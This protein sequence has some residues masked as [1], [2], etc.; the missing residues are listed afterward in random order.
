MHPS[1]RILGTVWCMC[2]LSYR[3]CIDIVVCTPLITP[4]IYVNCW[5]RGIQQCSSSITVPQVQAYGNCLQVR[6]SI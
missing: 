1:D 4:D 2:G 6:T 3:E 5:M